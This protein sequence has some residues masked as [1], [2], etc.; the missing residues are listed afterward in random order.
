[1]QLREILLEQKRSVIQESY[2]AKA[3]ELRS[4]KEAAKELEPAIKE[5]KTDE[6]FKALNDKIDKTDEEIKKLSEELEAIGESLKANQKELDEAVEKSK[7]AKE[8]AKEA[9]EEKE[10]KEV[11]TVEEKRNKA[12]ELVE[13]RSAINAYIRSRGAKQE[14]A[15]GFKVVD[16]GALIPKEI[17]APAKKK[18]DTVDL[19]KY[20]RTV[21]VN[22]GSGVLPVLS[23]SKAKMNTVE[24]L[25]ENPDLAKP[26][27]NEVDFKI[28][29][30]RGALAV[31]NEVIDDAQYDVLGLIS[32]DINNQELN[33]KNFAIAEIMKKA[34]AVAAK[35]LDGI[36]TAVNKEVPMV[37]N[38]KI[39][40][41]KSLYNELDLLKDKNGRYMIQPDVTKESGEKL[42]NKEL[43]VVDDTILG[44][45]GDLKAFYGDLYEFVTY[46]DRKQ[47]TV[48]WDYF[49]GYGKK[50]GCAI[51]FDAVKTAEDAGVLITYTAA[52]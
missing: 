10:N 14:R 52:V 21:K 33:T 41:T 47:T 49:D 50:L 42:F 12:E 51:R 48:G 8:A 5:A 20:V 35:G 24:E 40:V 30:Y 43:V 37:Y 2:D 36:K 18:E 38:S 31:S 6:D 15:D 3:E 44:A 34:R 17:L 28:K 32:E 9:A 27:I 13:V 23:K 4:A 29:T 16:G 39:F 1:M 45:E 7:E 11:T 19:S 22:T 26:A 46:F 25:V